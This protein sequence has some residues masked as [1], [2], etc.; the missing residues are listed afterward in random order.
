MENPGVD[1]PFP[2]MAPSPADMKA[3]PPLA[4]LGFGLI[5]CLPGCAQPGQ[6]GKPKKPTAAVKTDARAHHPKHLRVRTTAYIGRKNAIG[7][8]LKHGTVTSAASD[9]SKFPLGTRFR[10]RET[11]KEYI[12]DDYGSALVGT[13]TLDLAK[14]NNAG[15]RQW[16]ARWVNIDI[17][18]WG[19][20]RRSL[21]VL[22]PRQKYRHIRPMVTALK[23]QAEGLPAEFH[24][25]ELR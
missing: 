20:P 11:G 12:V 15:I 7:G 3:L 6:A 4:L 2:R 10:I 25:T 24:R 9:W 8:P 23:A 17:L 13:L 19:S 21:E 18:E 16:G 1:L 22:K 14:R 5:F